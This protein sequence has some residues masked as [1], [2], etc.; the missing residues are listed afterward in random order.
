MYCV[1]VW[2]RWYLQFKSIFCFCGRN[3]NKHPEG[4]NC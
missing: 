4:M 1:V 2:V 3:S